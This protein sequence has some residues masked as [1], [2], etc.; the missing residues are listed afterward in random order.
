MAWEFEDGKLHVNTT[1]PPN[2]AGTVLLPPTFGR[3]WAEVR[4][5]GA[6]IYQQGVSLL[7]EAAG[8]PGLHGIHGDRER[9]SICIGGGDF[10]FAATLGPL[11]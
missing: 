3:S 4:E 6:V 7:G 5:G 10:A 1:L 9:L 2:T 8:L 11:K